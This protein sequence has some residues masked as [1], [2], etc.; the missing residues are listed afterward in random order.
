[1][2]LLISWTDQNFEEEDS[3]GGDIISKT[4]EHTL[5][6]DAVTK[7]THESTAFLTSHAVED[8]VA[9]SDHKRPEPR[10]VS[11]EVIVSNTPITDPLPSG[12]DPTTPIVGE[13][14]KAE[15]GVS[16]L[17]YSSAFDRRNDVFLT[18]D[19]LL[20][21]PVVVT[22]STAVTKYDRMSIVSVSSP[23][24]SKDGSTIRFNIEA[25]E[26]RIARA[27]LV[28]S[29][30]PREPRARRVRDVGAR[31]ASSSDSNAQTQSLA[32]RFA[33]SASNGDFGS[34]L[35]GIVG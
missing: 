24:E 8:G 3:G 30:Q 25:V 26:V 32:S 15:S 22:I 12:F 9:L 27:T 29:P 18:L 7:E 5:Q 28:D 11:L 35:Q 34:V 1:M 23:R 31:E 16:V 33:E 2:V 19:R 14:R 21:E 6:F 20:S 17:Q 13:V 10:R 4:V